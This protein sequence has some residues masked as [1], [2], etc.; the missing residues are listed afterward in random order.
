LTRI[1]LVSSLS[2]GRCTA[3]NRRRVSERLQ[4]EFA[5]VRLV[6]KQ[7]SEYF[8]I[9]V[10]FISQVYIFQPISLLLIVDR[11][12][13]SLLPALRDDLVVVV[14][15]DQFDCA[16]VLSGSGP[17]STPERIRVLDSYAS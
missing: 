14:P 17:R 5:P 15:I 8:S 1:T 16:V 2:V 7:N 10:T 11:L 13:R 9:S 3:E 4:R 12:Q 6:E